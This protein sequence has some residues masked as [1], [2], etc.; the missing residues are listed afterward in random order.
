MVKKSIFSKEELEFIKIHHIPIEEFYD[1]RNVSAG[2]SKET[3][4][5]LGKSFIIAGACTKNQSHRLKTRARHCI[6]CEPKYIE[7]M[8]RE[9]KKSWIYISLANNGRIFKVGLAADLDKRQETLCSQLYGGF[10][11]WKMLVA[12]YTDN[13]GMMERKLADQVGKTPVEGYY[14][15]DFGTQKATEMY[16]M[17]DDYDVEFFIGRMMKIGLWEYKFFD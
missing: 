8:K 9:S 16:L 2:K 12:A 10:D 1:G 4:K 5:K 11:D 3:A 15:K 14:E 13:A 6:Q 7:F 17:E